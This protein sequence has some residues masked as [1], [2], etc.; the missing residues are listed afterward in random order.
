[1][2][3]TPPSLPL[4]SGIVIR[5]IKLANCLIEPKGVSACAVARR[6]GVVDNGA[7][8][9]GHCMH[10]VW[11]SRKVRETSPQW[12]SKLTPAPGKL[13]VACPYFWQEILKLCDMGLS[14]NLRGTSQC[15]S[16]CGT[17]PCED[18]A[19]GDGG[20]RLPLS[21]CTPGTCCGPV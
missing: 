16:F 13:N 18:R 4:S 19:R 5:D 9:L 11:S 12:L 6:R 7:E 20:L 1:M 14:M 21:G 3:L 10:G 8:C 17:L 2:P 15:E